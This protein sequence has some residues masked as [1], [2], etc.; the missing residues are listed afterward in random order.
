MSSSST[1]RMWMDWQVFGHTS[2]SGFTLIL[3]FCM[4][5]IKKVKANNT[6]GC[7]SLKEQKYKKK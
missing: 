1:Y 6:S 7:N 5:L 2:E 3:I 4:S